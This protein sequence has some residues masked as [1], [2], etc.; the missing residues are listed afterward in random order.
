MNQNNSAVVEGDQRPAKEDAAVRWRKLI[1]QQG[2][3]GFPVSACCR[4]RGISPASFFAWR[5]RGAAAARGSSRETGVEPRFG[6]RERQFP[7]RVAGGEL[8]MELLRLKKWYYGPRADRLARSADVAQMLL[9]FAEELEARPV[10]TE[11]LEPQESWPE[12]E[13]VRRVHSDRRHLAAFGNLPALR[14]SHSQPI[15]QGLRQ[16]LWTW[17]DQLLPK[18]PMAEAVNYL[19]QLLTNLPTT[20]ISRPDQW[21]PEQWKRRNPTPSE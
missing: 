6:R 11:D 5:R 14:Q 3:S 20:P 10:K 17:K 18:H 2:D 16:R 12:V 7:D 13:I 15:L 19:T 21:L 1:E 4:E 9:R 8:E